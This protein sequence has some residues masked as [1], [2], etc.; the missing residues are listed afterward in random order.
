[1]A[2]HKSA[3]ADGNILKCNIRGL[4]QIF[5]SRRDA[6]VDRFVVQHCRHH[7]ARIGLHADLFC[8]RVNRSYHADYAIQFR[9][10]SLGARL[11][12]QQLKGG[13]RR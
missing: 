8:I 9:S 10:R 7:S 11:R 2:A 13:E 1:M 6:Q 12:N 5:L 4:F 3:I